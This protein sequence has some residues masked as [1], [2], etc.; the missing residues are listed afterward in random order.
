MVHHTAFPEEASAVSVLN[1]SCNRPD[2]HFCRASLTAPSAHQVVREP[3][4]PCWESGDGRSYKKGRRLV[5][6]DW[7]R[8]IEVPRAC[9]SQRQVLEMKAQASG[10]GG[11]IV[12]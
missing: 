6:E 5:Q 9:S 7:Y 2:P 3:L 12:E 10:G 1:P 4:C 8:R 11:Q